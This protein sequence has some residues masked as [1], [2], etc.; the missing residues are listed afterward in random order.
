M[1]N[2]LGA[3]GRYFLQKISSLGRSFV[4][5]INVLLVKPDF[6]RNTL[7]LINEVYFVGV[8]SVIIILVSGLFIGMVL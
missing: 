7:L 5:L 3:L 6:K 1:L 4:M 8:Q 2:F